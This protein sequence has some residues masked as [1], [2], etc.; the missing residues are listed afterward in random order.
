MDLHPTRSLLTWYVISPLLCLSCSG[1]DGDPTPE[2]TPTP[3]VDTDQDPGA[4]EVET[5]APEPNWVTLSTSGT[6]TKLTVK[7]YDSSDAG[8]TH[9]LTLKYRNKSGTWT[10]NI[11]GGVTAGSSA[12]CTNIT[13]SS[14]ETSN[15]EDNF[16]VGYSGSSN[17]DGLLFTALTVTINGSNYSVSVFAEQTNKVTCKDCESVNG[18]SSCW[19]DGD[20]HND[21]T[22][23][24]VLMETYGAEG[25]DAFTSCTGN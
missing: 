8:T 3:A 23:V 22:Q 1:D 25:Y 4:D 20:G 11:S 17:T 5:P 2:P 13:Q 14:T 12:S 21:C 24:K 18:C 15:T 19:I 6:P 9:P 10:C 7:A 16:Y